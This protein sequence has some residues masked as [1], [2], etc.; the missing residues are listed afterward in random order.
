[1]LWFHIKKL[2][3]IRY[4]ILFKV[5]LESEFL[6]HVFFLFQRV[7]II[8]F[9][10]FYVICL[11]AQDKLDSFLASIHA[12]P[13]APG[14]CRVHGLAD[15]QHRGNAPV[16][17]DHAGPVD[18]GGFGQQSSVQ[19]VDTARAPNTGTRARHGTGDSI[20][21]L[22]ASSRSSSPSPALVWSTP[23]TLPPPPYCTTPPLVPHATARAWGRARGGTVGRARGTAQRRSSVL[24]TQ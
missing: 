12:Q 10:M 23:R 24:Q 3:F 4:E 9:N 1:M 5:T 18:T 16:R 8:W 14:A 19:E 6:Y 11:A 17:R 13:G 22:T 20:P 2:S 21:P 15:R 7:F